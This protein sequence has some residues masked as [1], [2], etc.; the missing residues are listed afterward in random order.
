MS[1][2]T[3]NKAN[4][5]TKRKRKKARKIKHVF[6][7][8]L[9]PDEAIK[10]LSNIERKQLVRARNAAHNAFD[11]IW[12]DL[13]LY[14]RPAAYFMLAKRMGLTADECHMRTMTYEQCMQVIDIANEI[15]A[16]L[17]Q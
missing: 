5:A 4:H 11:P 10:N 3:F 13:E 7:N 12:K 16:P 8:K 6:S 14:T 1:K 2:S 15:K 9:L 17:R